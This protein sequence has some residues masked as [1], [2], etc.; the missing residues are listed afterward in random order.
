MPFVRADGTICQEHGYDEATGIWLAMPEGLRAVPD[1]PTD[2][3]IAEARKLMFG[4]VLKDFPWVSN[5]DWANYVALL[6]TPMLREVINGLSPFGVVTAAMAGSGKS[7]LT[8]LI[9]EIHGSFPSELS[10]NDEETRKKITTIFLN[11]MVP[12]VTFDNIGAGHTLDSPLLAQLLT[13]RV[14]NDRLLGGNSSVSRINDKLW[15]ATGNNI[16]LGGDMASR[17]VYVRIDPRV[18][19]PGERDTTAFAVGNLDTWMRVPANRAAMTWALLVMVRA[20]AAK[21]MPKSSV[22]MR[23]FTPWAQALGGLLE[24]H[25]V[26]GFLTNRDDVEA[27]DDETVDWA[28]FLT[29]WHERH[30]DR[31]MTA[32]QLLSDYQ[33]SSVGTYLG[34]TDPWQGAF[35]AGPGGR[36]LTAKGLGKKFQYY[37]DRPSQ[38]WTLRYQ[39]VPGRAALWKAEPFSPDEAAP[40]VVEQPS[41]FTESD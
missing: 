7:L 14:W 22:E 25:G 26:A 34:D 10:R 21:G 28:H 35:P 15:L 36:P 16:R 11:H 13:T 31:W 33:K 9:G 38:G 30:A 2:T 5:A 6:F 1:Q 32:A 18:E 24:F 29:V 23:T 27:A 20:W 37:R 40:Q 12:V 3:E 8:D 41:M 4:S 19:R 17:S 39:A